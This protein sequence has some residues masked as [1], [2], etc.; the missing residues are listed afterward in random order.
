MRKYAIPFAVLILLIVIG[1][2]VTS[3]GWISA[4]DLR[5]RLVGIAM[6]LIGIAVVVRQLGRFRNGPKGKGKA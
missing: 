2:V 5:G 1:T 3:S 4:A 6:L